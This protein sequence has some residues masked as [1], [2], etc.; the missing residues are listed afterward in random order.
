VNVEELCSV[1]IIFGFKM[2]MQSTGD[3]S[4]LPASTPL[5]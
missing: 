4:V 3:A 1:G 2:K 5:Y